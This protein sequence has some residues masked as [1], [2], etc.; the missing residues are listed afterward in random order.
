MALDGQHWYLPDGSPFYEVAARDGHMR[1]VTLADARKVN[2]VPSVTTVRRI[3]A[4][5]QLEAWKTTQAVLA[6][7][8]LPRIEGES[9]AALLARIRQDGAQQAVGAADEGT[10]IHN[11]LEDAFHGRVYPA[12]YK[13][14]VDAVMLRLGELF[15][16]V[17]DWVS[18]ASFCHPS[19]YGG[20]IDLH[21]PS[22]GIVVDYKGTEG[23]CWQDDQH[24]YKRVVEDGGVKDKR[25][26]WDQ[27]IQLAAYQDGKGL[28]HNVCVNL[29]VSRTDP[30]FVAH[31]IW[32][33]DEIAYGAEYFRRELALWQHVN[34]YAPEPV[35]LRRSPLSAMCRKQPNTGGER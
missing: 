4:Q 19:G 17:H 20:K 6:A 9:S 27:Y 7:L 21:S 10:R 3:S 29:F 2:A 16:T 33:V 8:T 11:A 30:G 28:P 13:S 22:T 31:R 34:R 26:D 25:C 15:P 12:Q 24:A 14:H 5:P 23:Q 32:S 1:P 35:R 18:E